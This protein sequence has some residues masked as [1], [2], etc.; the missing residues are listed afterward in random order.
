ML[1]FDESVRLLAHVCNGPRALFV[2]LRVAVTWPE[3]TPDP[4][5]ISVTTAIGRGARV[6]GVGNSE[7]L[8]GVWRLSMYD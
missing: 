1:A 7:P 8:L 4:H 5:C 3:G 2:W 6:D